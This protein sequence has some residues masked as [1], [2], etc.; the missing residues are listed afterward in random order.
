MLIVYACHAAE[1]RVSEGRHVWGLQLFDGTVAT[2]HLYPAVT[3]TMRYTRGS[4]QLLGCTKV[5]LA[6][7][8]H[9][10]GAHFDWGAQVV[11]YREPAA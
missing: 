1:R 11:S 4:G 6:W 7:A 9:V 2:F 5:V 10:S 8:E 3:T